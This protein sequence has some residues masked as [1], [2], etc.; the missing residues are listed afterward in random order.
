LRSNK[1]LDGVALMQNVFSKDNPILRFNDLKDNTDK[2]EQLGFMW[3]YSGAVMG[4]RN[5]RAHRIIAD[6]PERALEF[7]AFISLLAKMLDES[8]D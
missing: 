6:D 7:I 1:E 3:L 8:K 2:D 5:P 4:L